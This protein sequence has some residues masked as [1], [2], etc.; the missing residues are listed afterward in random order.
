MKLT[1]GFAALLIMTTLPAMAAVPSSQRLQPAGKTWGESLPEGEKALYVRV[2]ESYREG[3]LTELVKFKDL[4]LKRYPKSIHADNTL[5]LTGML[6]FHRDQTAEA[7][8]L[9]GQVVER[10]GQGNKVPAALY[11]K[12]AIYSRLKLPD[13]SR[14]ML[15][16]IVKRFPGSPEAQR[17]KLDLKIFNQR[18]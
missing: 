7:L 11:A 8:R 16:D 18:S 14:K 9:F 3:N 6:F 10:Y 1:T 4:M 17:A 15:D 12:S 2:L 5:Y 13:L